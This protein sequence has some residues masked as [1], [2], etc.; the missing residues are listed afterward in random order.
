MDEEVYNFAE[1]IP[2]E[3]VCPSGREEFVDANVFDSRLW[4]V[5]SGG[6]VGGAILQMIV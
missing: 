3:D 5:V 2:F 1:L 4:M 6:G